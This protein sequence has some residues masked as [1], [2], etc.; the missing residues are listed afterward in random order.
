MSSVSDFSP[1]AFLRQREALL[2]HFNT[3]MSEHRTGFPE[4]LHDAANLRD[5]PISFSTIQVGDRGPCHVNP[6]SDANAGGS[7]GLVVDI[8]DSGSIVTVGP[9]DD[10]TRASE[11]GQHQSGGSTADTISCADSI[12]YRVTAN[13]WF[14][15]DYIPLGIFVFLPAMVF[16]RDGAEQG[17]RPTDLK[18][19]LAKFPDQRLFAAFS[20]SFHEFDR[21]TCQWK[22]VAYGDI[23]PA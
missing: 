18:E 20:G 13:E 21:T 19:I 10:G 4:D 5:T 12:D 6:P 1:R 16:V 8:L 14:I 15:Q 17:E 3:P 2:V 11:T 23:V 9:G 7:I 22:V